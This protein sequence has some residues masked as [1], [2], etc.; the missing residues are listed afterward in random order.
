MYCDPLSVLSRIRLK[1]DK[2]CQYTA[3]R[4]TKRLVDAGIAPSTGSVG[5]S[6]D[7][8]LAE[9]LWSTLKI[10]LIHWTAT[11]FATRSEAQSALFRYIDGWFGY[12]GNPRR[13]SP[14]SDVS[15]WMLGS[16]SGWCPCVGRR[17]PGAAAGTPAA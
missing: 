3:V 4:F 10:E 11:T 5:D 17:W 2:G 8:A 13:V 6:F 16:G 12:A 9:N 7:N 1:S 15:A 14:R